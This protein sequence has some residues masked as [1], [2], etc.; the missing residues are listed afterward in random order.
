VSGSYNKPEEWKKGVEKKKS[1]YGSGWSI[2][3]EVQTPSKLKTQ[4]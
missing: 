3:E 2:N 1:L 4:K